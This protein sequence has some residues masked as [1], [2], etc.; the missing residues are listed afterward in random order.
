MQGLSINAMRVGLQYRLVNFD[1][2]Y[3]FET[4]KKLQEDNFLLKDLHTLEKYELHDLVKYG[5]GKDF[6]IRELNPNV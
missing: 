2:V 4:L 6:E 5:R 1:E 3:E